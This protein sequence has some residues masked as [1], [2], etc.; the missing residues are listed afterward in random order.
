MTR[1]EKAIQALDHHT[2][3]NGTSVDHCPLMILE[4]DTL[5]ELP[6]DGGQFTLNDFR[7]LVFEFKELQ[8]RMDGLEK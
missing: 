3:F 1:L 4:G 5:F 2:S 8:W 7:V 6:H